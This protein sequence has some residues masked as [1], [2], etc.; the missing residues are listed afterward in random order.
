MGSL[1]QNPVATEL[2]QIHVPDCWSHVPWPLQKPRWSQAAPQK[3][4]VHVPQFA[5]VKDWFSLRRDALHVGPAQYPNALLA[6]HL[7]VFVWESQAPWMQLIAVQ[8]PEL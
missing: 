2:V 5:P 7:Q 1:A 6:E 8:A 4:P 3:P